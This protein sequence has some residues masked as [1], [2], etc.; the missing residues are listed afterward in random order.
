MRKG[1]RLAGAILLLVVL[2]VTSVGVAS[3]APRDPFRGVWYAV[4]VDSSNMKMVFSGGGVSRRMLWQ[5]DYWSICAGGPGIGRGTGEVDGD[6]LHAT[7]DVYCGGALAGTFDMDFT[8]DS[9]TGTLLNHVFVVPPV[10]VTWYRH[11]K[12]IP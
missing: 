12:L 4:D 5:D 9:G 11:W 2:L 8:Y 3:A 7:V 1:I 6:T 10:D